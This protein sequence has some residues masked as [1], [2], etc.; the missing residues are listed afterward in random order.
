MITEVLVWALVAARD[1]NAAVPVY[2]HVV[3]V[4]TTESACLED[5]ELVRANF[6]EKVKCVL[7]YSVTRPER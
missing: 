4:Y 5:A 3:A 7:H 1:P 2:T 6:E